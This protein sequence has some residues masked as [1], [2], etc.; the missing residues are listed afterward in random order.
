M[1]KMFLQRLESTDLLALKDLLVQCSDNCTWSTML[2]EVSHPD[3][4][5]HWG[6][7]LHLP[8]SFKDRWEELPLEIRASLFILA[9]RVRESAVR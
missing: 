2:A 3:R 8:Q 1:T 9:N 6:W 4:G 5:N 7:F